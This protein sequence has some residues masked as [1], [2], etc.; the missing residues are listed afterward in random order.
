MAKTVR[1]RL[2]TD[3]YREPTTED[4][5][6]AKKYVLRRDAVANAAWELA[7]DYIMEYIERIVRVAYK[8]NIPPEKFSFDSSVNQKMMQEIADIMDEMDEALMELLQVES[9]S[10]TKDKDNKLWLIALLLT[11]GHKNMN[12]RDTLQAYEW[13]MLHQTGALIASARHMNMSQSDAIRMIRKYIG[14]VTQSPQFQSTLPYRQLYLN[15]FIHNGGRATFPDG[16]PNVSGVP[17]DG[18][19]A[20]RQLFINAI[21]QVWM[22]NQLLEWS[23]D[24]GIAGYYQLRGSNYPCNICDD[25]TGFHPGADPNEPFNTHPRCQCYRIP[26]YYNGTQGRQIS[27]E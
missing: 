22:K 9:T 5:E 11:L 17:V 8:Y 19:N 18:Y 15:P 10:C 3:R 21:S 23:Q 25:E 24:N 6:K 16:S 1:I 13:R 26:V 12:M 27:A 20:L 7:S 2:D 14:N 4:L